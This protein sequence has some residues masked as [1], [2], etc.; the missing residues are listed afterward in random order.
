M[1]AVEREVFC[2]R[3]KGKAWLQAPALIFSELQW[4]EELGESSAQSAQT[5]QQH[6]P[7]LATGTGNLPTHPAHAYARAMRKCH[8]VEG[9]SLR[10]L[11]AIWQHSKPSIALKTEESILHSISPAAICFGG[12]CEPIL[13]ACLCCRGSFDTASK[14]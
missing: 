12:P 7:E 3:A 14:A 2:C 6:A 8:H 9:H 5:A 4:E 11:A 1:E 13:I 10:V